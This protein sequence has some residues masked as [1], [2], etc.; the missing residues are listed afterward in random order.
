[1]PLHFPPITAEMQMHSAAVLDH[2][3][4]EIQK[5]GG[6]ISFARY[7]EL[8]LYSPG[9]GYYSSGSHKLGKIGDFITAP[10]I[11]PLFAKSVARQFSQILNQ[12]PDSDILEL[13][14]GT[15]IFAKDVLLEL[16]KTNC[17]PRRYSI[18]ETSADLRQRQ[19]AFLQNTCPDLYSRI[20]WLEHLPEKFK[21]VIFAN[22]V[23]DA[24]PVHCF[25]VEKQTV[26]ERC[27]SLKNQ[28]LTWALSPPLSS[29]L[30]DQVQ[31]L[32]QEFDLPP[33]YESEINL[34]LPH[35]IK[36]LAEILEIGTLIFFD[37]GYGRREYY[38]PQRSSGT[39][40]CYFQHRLHDNPFLFPGLQDL[41]CSIDFTR[42][43][44]SAVQA[45]LNLAG[46]TTQS[47]FL[48]AC[49]ITDFANAPPSSMQQYQQNLALK[50]LMLPSE[51]GSLVKALALTKN[52]HAELEGFRLFDKQREL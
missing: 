39:L 48:M 14:A 11:S 32:I 47:A 42:V 10:E 4:S 25:R 37:Y 16:K 50:L 1:M 24:L 8:V 5:A 9:L 26:L 41:T 51:M 18:L 36:T 45:G 15:G 43:V 49:G 52:W 44:E 28:Q 6:L 12:L 29:A 23:L 40:R 19:Q 31:T 22:E 38:H 35:W 33:D 21:G 17:L 13:G 27:V 7:M 2:V 20:H 34:L 30:N 3:H 46:Y